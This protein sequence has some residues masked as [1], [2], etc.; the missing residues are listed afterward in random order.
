M[1]IKTVRFN[2][3]ETRKLKRLLSY[4]RS[5]FSTCVKGLIEEKIEDL[6]DLG[7]IQKLKEGRT[8]EDYYTV[9]EINA[10]FN[11]RKKN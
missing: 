10:L 3:E 8:R 4:Y 6:S 9:K 2:K 1:S 7:V 5:D 11:S